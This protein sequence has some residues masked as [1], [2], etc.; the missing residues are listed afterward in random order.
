MGHSETK[1]NLILK[2]IASGIKG[3]STPSVSVS[4]TSYQTSD[5]DMNETF[6]DSILISQYE[7]TGS[8]FWIVKRI[9]EVGD[10]FNF[11]YATIENNP[12]KLTLDAAW[13]DRLTLLYEPPEGLTIL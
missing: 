7:S 12:T 3:L 11:L 4:M 8:D 10:S 1:T 5:I 6:L 9:Q 13:T 2:Q